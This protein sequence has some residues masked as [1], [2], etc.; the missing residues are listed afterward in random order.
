MA[1]NRVRMAEGVQLFDGESALS[2]KM[3]GRTTHVPSLTRL[4]GTLI[5]GF[6]W[7]CSFSFPAAGGP[8]KK[9]HLYNK[10]DDLQ[11]VISQSRHDPRTVVLPAG[12]WRVTTNL[13]VP[14]YITLRLKKGAS[15]IV[16]AS[17]KLTIKGNF[18]APVAPIFSGDGAIVFSSTSQHVYP[19]WWG[20]KG[21]GRTDD[22]CAIQKSIDA[23]ANIY[24]PEGVYILGKIT[25]KKNY[26][27]NL[28]L[29]LHSNLSIAGSGSKSVLRLADHILDNPNDNESNAHMMGGEN[30]S[31]VSIRKIQF[32]MNGSNNLV[33]ADKIRNAMALRIAGG[34]NVDI[35]NCLFHNCAGH[36][37][38]VLS[39]GRNDRNSG[40]RIH[41]NIFRN[42]GR[43][44]GTP[45]ENIHN[46]DFSFVYIEWEDAVVQ[47]N[48]IEQEDINIGMHNYSGGVEIHGS[49]SKVLNNV[50]IGCDPAIYIATAPAPIEDVEV[51]SNTMH[52][53]ARGVSFFLTTKPPKNIVI[54]SNTI[55][56]NQSHLRTGAGECVGIEVPNGAKRIFGSVHAS[57]SPITGLK[58]TDNRIESDLAGN[59]GC[60]SVG[61][62]IHSLHDAQIAGNRI[63]GMTGCGIKFI[64]SPWGSIDVIITKNTILDCGANVGSSK[65]STG[66]YFAHDGYSIVPPRSYYVKNITITDNLIGNTNEEGPQHSGMVF[67]NLPAT[68]IENLYV[69]RNRFMNL[70]SNLCDGDKSL[71]RL[72]SLNPEAH[73][74]P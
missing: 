11:S 22:T 10:Q 6:L 31:N 73:Y 62:V 61:M 27:E 3:S 34:E 47:E 7:V 28:I 59:D 55:L 65:D 48:I 40:A 42:G 21:D 63:A 5:L 32:D 36:N 56:L 68:K 51:S 38:L 60:R 4:V 53:C 2:M 46:P 72:E 58:I 70:Q 50:I 43:Y 35:E 45:T 23:G 16:P 74:V 18:S 54:S 44:V 25:S 39:I 9:N 66:I 1:E 67:V 69:G 37:V 30:L 17:T 26:L 20:A 15:V 64:G 24:L 13:V 71:A 8:L 29:T 52:N 57:A 14:E 49:H 41:N 19:Q 12:R 33:P